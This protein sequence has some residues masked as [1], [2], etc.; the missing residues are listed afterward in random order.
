MVISMTK[1]TSSCSN[2]LTK[3]AILMVNICIYNH[4]SKLFAREDHKAVVVLMC[5]LCT[6]RGWLW[7]TWCKHG[8]WGESRVKLPCLSMRTF[9]SDSRVGASYISMAQ[10]FSVSRDASCMN[11]VDSRPRSKTTWYGLVGRDSNLIKVDDDRSFSKRWS[12]SSNTS[13]NMIIHNIFL[14]TM[15]NFVTE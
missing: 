15:Q 13:R 9:P 4:P 3:S 12:G 2:A 7:E 11:N 6:E 1:G 10:E 14:V 8:S 5:A